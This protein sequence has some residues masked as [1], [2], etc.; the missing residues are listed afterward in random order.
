M[1]KQGTKYAGRSNAVAAVPRH[2]RNRRMPPRSPIT[3]TQIKKV[4]YKAAETKHA[5]GVQTP[6]S[7]NSTVS[8]ISDLY[9]VIPAVQAGTGNNARI[10]EKISPS[11][12]NIRGYLTVDTATLTPS[13]IDKLDVD[14][15]IL[16][17]KYQRD[18]TVRDSTSA[19]FMRTGAATINYDGTLLS[20]CSPVDT[21][22]FTVLKRLNVM[23]IP[24]PITSG[25]L[26]T[27]SN[28]G[29]NV[30]KFNINIPLSKD[31]ATFE[32]ADSSGLQP[33]N[34][35]MFLTCGFVQ[36]MDPATSLSSLYVQ[37]KISYTSTLYYKDL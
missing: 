35:N 31:H 28:H 37:P 32:F 36:Y 8:G 25:Q 16:E 19:K 7:F 17:D 34:A 6:V 22:R 1:A 20:S 29:A 21:D 30:Y 15:F 12:L 11:Y 27:N 14:M 33:I 2:S 3:A 4:M 13:A 18:G 23:L 9:S 5:Y 26:N 24:W 10:G